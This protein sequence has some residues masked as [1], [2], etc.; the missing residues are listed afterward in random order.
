VE[1][2]G[3]LNS[4]IPALRLSGP[5]RSSVALEAL[6]DDYIKSFQYADPVRSYDD[7]LTHFSSQLEPVQLEGTKDDAALVQI[8]REAPGQTIGT[9]PPG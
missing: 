1:S 2:I 9:E 6:A 5:D 4:V 8:L 3:L 7:L